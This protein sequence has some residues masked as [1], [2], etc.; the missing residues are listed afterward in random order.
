MRVTKVSFV[1]FMH[2]RLQHP[3]NQILL[4]P[5]M[6]YGKKDGPKEEAPPVPEP[7]KGFFLDVRA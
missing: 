6:A 1:D 3:S 5:A 4:P 2:D 7:G